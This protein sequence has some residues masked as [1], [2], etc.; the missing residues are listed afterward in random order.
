MKRIMAIVISIIIIITIIL[1][2]LLTVKKDDTQNEI[3]PLE[4]KSDIITITDSHSVEYADNRTNS[5]AVNR[6][7]EEYINY[8]VGER[9]NELVNI[10]SNK[11][12]QD[13]NITVN[14]IVNKVKDENIQYSENYK[15]IVNNMYVIKESINLES[16]LVDLTYCNLDTNKNYETK[17]MVQIDIENLTFCI[18]PYKYIQKLGYDKLKLGDS[19]TIEHKQIEK[20]QYNIYKM[21]PISKNSTA[22]RY[23][24][25][26][27][28]YLKYDVQKSYE[29]LEVQYKQSK[30]TNINEYIQYVQNNKLQEHALKAYNV[31]TYEDYSQYVCIDNQDRYYIFNEKG[32]MNYSVILDTYTIDLQEFTEKYTKA[33]DEEK[34]LLN[35]Q[36]CFAAINDKDYRYVYNKL[37]N[38]FKSNNFKTLADFEKYINTNFFEKNKI[39]ASNAKK[40]NG[41]YL[42][43]IKISDNDGVGSITKTFVMQLKDGTDFVMSF[44]V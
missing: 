14:N 12:I 9:S 3:G 5:F 35:I 1:I 7:V 11:C 22:E 38:T 24:N 27:L 23:F 44:G 36:K 25:T 10:I 29:L 16:Y 37:D 30:F 8:I 13:E 2:I 21:T 26:F 32:I 28:E 43:D 20:N 34:V 17:L 18:M 31:Y 19:C 39:S 41:V 42:Y 33:S 40:Q 4:G 15:V 6:I